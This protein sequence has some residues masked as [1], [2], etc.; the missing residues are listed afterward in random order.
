MHASAGKGD[1]GRRDA[2]A[3]RRPL[4][5]RPMSVAV[6]AGASPTQP[7]AAYGAYFLNGDLTGIRRRAPQ[8]E[9]VDREQWRRMG[10]CDAAYF[11]GG[12][13]AGS[14]TMAILLKHG[15]RDNYAH[16]DPESP[17][18]HAGKEA[19]WADAGR[20]AAARPALFY[21]KFPECVSKCGAG[22]PRR[23][24]LDACPHYTSRAQAEAIACVH[25]DT[26]FIMLVR[27]P[28]S[29]VV[30]RYNAQRVRA[31]LRTPVDEYMRR[32]Q[33]D[34][35]WMESRLSDYAHILESFLQFFDPEQ[36]IVVHSSALSQDPP[37]LQKLMDVVCDHLG[38]AHRTVALIRSNDHSHK[39]SSDY[40]HP[41]AAL[42][43]AL[44]LE[45]AP[46]VQRL[47][48]MLGANLGWEGYAAA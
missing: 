43:A 42:T 16:H 23:V 29:R 33:R 6:P 26:R 27:E 31:G 44:Q 35:G 17:F 30:S 24:A 25:P 9:G 41:S 28:V 18:S 20:S 12:E 15:P 36:I 46:S 13:K 32:L 14:T 2:P 5:H 11:L 19:C 22:E 1:S 8:C 40:L 38:V 37:E 39:A 3:A 48:A 21:G 4:P 47:Y 45:L 10:C 7:Y 34:P